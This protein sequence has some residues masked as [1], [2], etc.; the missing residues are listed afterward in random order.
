MMTLLTIIDW[1]SILSVIIA[2]I[3]GS[4]VSLI[5]AIMYFKPKLRKANAEAK[6]LENRNIQ[7]EFSF[8]SNRIADLEEKCERAYETIAK[9]D[10]KIDAL[11]N[12]IIALKTKEYESRKEKIELL[13]T[14]RNQYKVI[15]LRGDNECDKRI[16]TKN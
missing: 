2:G 9:K 16:T 15:C 14:I 5:G 3:T 1:N 12:E 11:Q 13:A 8:Q 7:A 6:E 10:E 4:G